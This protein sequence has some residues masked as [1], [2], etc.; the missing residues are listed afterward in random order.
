MK[1]Q[2]KRTISI[3]LVFICI[4]ALV[5]A[6]QTARASELVIGTE[7]RLW[8]A[9]GFSLTQRDCVLAAVS[10]RAAVYVMK[11]GNFDANFLPD[12]TIP[13]AN[14]Q[15][16]ADEFDRIFHMF[17]NPGS[18]FYTGDPWIAPG[19]DKVMIILMDIDG[20]GAGTGIPAGWSMGR[21]VARNTVATKSDMVIYLDIATRQGAAIFNNDPT[22]YFTNLAHEYQHYINHSAFMR[23]PSGS[24]R[25]EIWLDEALAELSAMN[26]RGR[27]PSLSALGSHQFRPNFSMV[28]NNNQWRNAEASSDTT[29]INAYYATVG[30]LAL[31]LQESGANIAALVNDHTNHGNEPSLRMAG[32][33]HNGQA[34]IE[35]FDALFT[36]FAL[37]YAVD[38]QSGRNPRFTSFGASTHGSIDTFHRQLTEGRATRFSGAVAPF[39]PEYNIWWYRGSIGMGSNA[40]EVEL[41]D[42]APLPTTTSPTRFFVIYS[43]TRNNHREYVELTRNGTTTV[44][45]GQGN[46]F[47]VMSVTYFT[48]NTNATLTFNGIADG[49]LAS[50]PIGPPT[51][52]RATVS[53]SDV[54]LNWS[55][56]STSGGNL[57]AT[58]YDIYRDGVL[59]G[60][61]TTTSY[62]DAGLAAMSQH[63]Y[64]VRARNGDR[65]S[66]ESNTVT[67]SLG[68]L[69]AP[70]NLRAT[71]TGND[72]RLTWTAPSTSGG[73]IR[74]TSYEIY[75]D[76]T[77]IG[78]ST[79]TS[80]DDRGLEQGR[81]YSYTVRAR[82]D[83]LSSDPSSA[84]TANV[85]GINAP[86]S[87]TATVVDG[88]SV[89]LRWSRGSTSGGAVAPTSYDV[90]RNDILITNVTAT[91]FRDTG[92]THGTTYTY[93]V[94]ARSGT[95]SSQRSNTAEVTVGSNVN[96]PTGFTAV[97]SSNNTRVELR[98]TAPAATGGML[99]AK[100]YQVFRDGEL[101][102]ET[103]NRS[104]NDTTIA[105][106]RTYVYSVR[107][108]SDDAVSVTT[109][110]IPVTVPRAL[111]PAPNFNDVRPGQ[112]FYN[113][114]RYAYQLR[115]ISG[116]SSTTYAPNEN[117]TY[118]EAIKLAA[119]MHQLYTTGEITLVN[120][121]PW[122][123]TFVDYARANGIIGSRN[124]SWNAS[125]TRA[126]YM[127]IFARALPDSALPEINTVR[128]GSIPDVPMSHPN[129]Q[130]IYKLYRAGILRGVNSARECRPAS[131]ILRSEVAAVVT[132]MMD[133]NQR[134]SFTMP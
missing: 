38:D 24:V 110:P 37:R 93:H 63:S 42:T 128:D 31:T 71:V 80:Y 127:E 121:N 107:A 105:A 79:T 16:I 104:F 25:K 18:Q 114:V 83:D 102:T 39:M 113:D 134:I 27:L 57:P 22:R 76:G 32:L 14:A 77:L 5:P 66:E 11:D 64:I 103:S 23:A 125:I 97:L 124:Y 87:L 94:I 82:S 9:T 4:A 58:S 100:T 67:A 72:V 3:F 55:A 74:A 122:Y 130:A 89:N 60:T 6:L 109:D 12:D 53:Q 20:D 36:D 131:N 26:Y 17:S 50:A 112:W 59:I 21:F 81:T 41:T 133:S 118:A 106:G 117:L 75:R 69:R 29:F 101:L 92:L 34:T 116:R 48:T 99:P 68:T 54:T 90:Y 28:P 123:Q 91:N 120:G 108:K 95:L 62:R 132:R 8:C 98:W 129:A 65:V 40:I 111:R 1:Q 30:L 88:T 73:N 85:G 56:P 115:L 33:A 49:E 19:T 45:I 47:M 86:T 84:A 126:E 43:P 119:C 44:P 51:N 96:P 10:N 52:L 2:I 61:S 7:E 70:T 78:T 46:S 15:R 35:G 13:N